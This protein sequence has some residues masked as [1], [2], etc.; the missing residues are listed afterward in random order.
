MAP[1]KK[2]HKDPGKEDSDKKVP[3]RQWDEQPGERNPDPVEQ[4]KERER[5]DPKKRA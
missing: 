5:D 2:P 1:E 4:Q 3:Q